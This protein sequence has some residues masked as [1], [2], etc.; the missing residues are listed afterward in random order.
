MAVS[1]RIPVPFILSLGLVLLS[2]LN[3]LLFHTVAELF[4]ICVAWAMLA[5]MWNSYEFARHH[6][7]MFLSIGFFWLAG[8]DL[9][10]TLAYK[11]LGIFPGQDANLPTQLW[12]AA[13][14][15]EAL[16]LLAGPSFIDRPIYR[17]R[18]L[19]GGG[20]LVGVIL[21]A[22][23]SGHFPD[24]FVEGSGLTPFKVNSEYLIIALLMAALV[25]Y[26]H[27]R[28]ALGKGLF[29]GL[30]LALVFTAISEL[31]FTYYVS[32]YGLSNLVGH[33]L[34][35]LAFWI[36]YSAVIRYPYQQMFEAARGYRETAERLRE[37]EATYRLL[38]ET[39]PNG[40]I[41]QDAEGRVT[42]AN[43]AAQ[44]ILGM[45][46]EAMRQAAAVG[47]LR[48]VGAAGVP[49]VEGELPA[50]SALAS[51]KP[52]RRQVV[53]VT[54]PGGSG[55]T[56]LEVDAIPLKDDTGQVH[57]VYSTLADITDRRRAERAQ[58]AS[59]RRMEL[60]L[61]LN[62]ESVGL[63]EAEL[64]RRALG[65]VVELTGSRVGYLLNMDSDRKA[66][67]PVVWTDEALLSS[68]APDQALSLKAVPDLW[69][70]CIRQRRPVIE[71]GS[72][73]DTS[74]HQTSAPSGALRRHLSVP[75]V[76]GDTV[77]MVLGVGNKATPY[78]EVDVDQLARVAEEVRK[79]VV[80]LRLEK[81]MGEAKEAAE[82]SSQAK[83]DFL[84]NM[85]HELR[86]PLNGILGYAHILQQQAERQ[87]AVWRHA[88]TIERSG[89]HLLSLINEIL[90]LSRIEA[91]RLT[92]NP[93]PTN[94]V[95]LLQDALLLI[96]VRA[97]VRNL[98]VIESLGDLP[99]MVEADGL[100]L[101][102]VLLN[103]LGNAVKFTE[104]GCI[105]LAVEALPAEGRQTLLRFEVRD[106]GPGIAGDQ[107][108][109]I[110]EPF[111]R[112]AGRSAH[113]EGA[114]LGLTI[115]R[116]LVALMGGRLELASRRAGEAWNATAEVGPPLPVDLPHGTV[117]WF[118]L[119]LRLPDDSEIVHGAAH[120]VG[121][122][123]PAPSLVVVD[124][125]AENR[126][127][128]SELLVPLGCRVI[129]AEDGVQGIEAVASMQPD[130]VITDIRMPELDGYEV[131]RRIRSDPA[132]AAVKVVVHSASVSHTDRDRCMALGAH[133]FLPKPLH[134]AQLYEL[135]TQQLGTQWIIDREVAEPPESHVDEQIPAPEVL[136]H[137]IAAVDAGDVDE[138]LA[139]SQQLRKGFP[140][141]SARVRK[142]AESLDI[143]ELG[144]FLR[145][146]AGQGSAPAARAG[147]RKQPETST[148]G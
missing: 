13:R 4:P 92:L 90:D 99:A 115:S 58:L 118:D 126:T 39:V 143:D 133:A 102:Q 7:L 116:R 91:D 45:S 98:A 105:T 137:L 19:V 139:A 20:L 9:V 2:Q 53:G 11:G 41:Y 23:F 67:L 66:L 38:F 59:A 132:F 15:L 35:F 147:E 148:V 21:W 145:S 119:R 34:K 71:N 3:F 54:S 106:T 140:A 81:A 61:A 107:F 50:L 97:E 100:R 43:P 94:L 24:A 141:L 117:I 44:R 77:V 123:D 55:T 79:F 85:S 129:E 5:V 68:A 47:G 134:V 57:Q 104:M 64:S 121:V 87:S 1:Y 89:E 62:R 32:V 103:L 29:R 146:L 17:R 113:I 65:G 73:P 70:E 114:G 95:E 51:G 138:L 74:G 124:D 10:H 84:A 12:I 56:W 144:D 30:A 136:G 131:I 37:S 122:V 22:A 16:L 78:D 36:L 82:Q 31:A 48:A 111:E 76:E 42:T 33:I 18:F 49:L 108:G 130:I 128:I 8:I 93:A 110:F 101:R 52:V 28:Q 25:R 88:R 135:L 75:V 26:Y 80:R 60:L 40:V 142:R 69:A 120:V 112:A 86:T 6:L 14:F 127:L 109:A 46:V 72:L 27:H 63:E 83:S 96:R 125:V